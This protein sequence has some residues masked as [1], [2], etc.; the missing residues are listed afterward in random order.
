MCVNRLAGE[1]RTKVT[2][3]FG[4]NNLNDR[5]SVERGSLGFLGVAA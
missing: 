3:K 2:F 1:V 4:A 5:A